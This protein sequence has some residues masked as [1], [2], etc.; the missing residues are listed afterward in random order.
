MLSHPCLLQV[1][2]DFHIETI[3][4]AAVSAGLKETALADI[5]I[6]WLSGDIIGQELTDQRL[7]SCARELGEIERDS[8]LYGR[9][10]GLAKQVGEA[11]ATMERLS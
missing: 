8:L 7:M 4:E 6:A 9:G 2:R 1:I 5:G 10:E 11:I 3:C